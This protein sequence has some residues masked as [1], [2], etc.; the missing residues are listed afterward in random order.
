MANHGKFLHID[1]QADAMRVVETSN[2]IDRGR[3]E[4]TEW[5]LIAQCHICTASMSVGS[6]RRTRQFVIRYM[7]DEWD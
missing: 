5:L 1:L 6:A 4:H 3:Y 7:R 2:Y